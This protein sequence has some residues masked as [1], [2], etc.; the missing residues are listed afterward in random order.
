MRFGIYPKQ[1]AQLHSGFGKV[2]LGR[3]ELRIFLKRGE[4]KKGGLFEK[5]RINTL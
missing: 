2:I 1:A 5:G 4:S 3:E